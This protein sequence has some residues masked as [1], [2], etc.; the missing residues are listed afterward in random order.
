VVHAACAGGGERRES[1]PDAPARI[2]AIPR[3]ERRWRTKA[4]AAVMRTCGVS[5]RT[6]WR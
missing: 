1:A 6:R 2:P 3:A 5:G 4:R